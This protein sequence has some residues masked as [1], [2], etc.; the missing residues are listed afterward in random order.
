MNDAEFREAAEFRIRAETEVSAFHK[1]CKVQ[2]DDLTEIVQSAETIFCSA[3]QSGAAEAY[4][5][6]DGSYLYMQHSQSAKKINEVLIGEAVETIRYSQMQEVM[7]ERTDG[8]LPNDSIAV[9]CQCIYDNLEDLCITNKAKPTMVQSWPKNLD[10][11]IVPQPA[12]PDLAETALEYKRT[13]AR[14]RDVRKRK[15]L[16]TEQLEAVTAQ[17]A[18]MIEAY[19]EAHNVVGKRIDVVPEGS[20][21][22]AAAGPSE[23]ELELPEVPQLVAVPERPSSSK[24]PKIDTIPLVIT[25]PP[26]AEARSLVV[27]RKQYPARGKLPALDVFQE[28][29]PDAIAPLLAED[30]Q[31]KK[32]ATKAGK[33]RITEAL[34]VVHKHMFEANKSEPRSKIA[35]RKVK[36]Q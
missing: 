8:G 17:T 31:L 23:P 7:R 16:G 2:E 21:M 32:W 14:L 33:Q 20:V 35:V 1:Q 36:Q 27:Q 34:C 30:P 10:S 13:R 15:R 25:A 11:A 5:F 12:P 28:A 3:L 29:I 9:L 26:E 4:R 19:L 22:A 6:D 18:P 24:R